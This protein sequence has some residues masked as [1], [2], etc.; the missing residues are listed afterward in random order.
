MKRN[1]YGINVRLM[2]E[3]MFQGNASDRDLASKEFGEFNFGLFHAK[4]I[5]IHG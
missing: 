4:H 2:Y 5:Y 3:V 1:G